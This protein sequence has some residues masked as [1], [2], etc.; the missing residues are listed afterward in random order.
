MGVRDPDLGKEPCEQHAQLEHQPARPG[1]ADRLPQET[2]A[3]SHIDSPSPNRLDQPLDLLRRMLAVGIERHQD[4]CPAFQG[5]AQTGLQGRT[6]TPVDDMPENPHRM[7]QGH[8]GG[9]VV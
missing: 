1:Q 6:L 2:G 7:P 8:P 9:I 5:E 4:H 3:Q